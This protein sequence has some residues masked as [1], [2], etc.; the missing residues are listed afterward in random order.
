MGPGPGPKSKQTSPKIWSQV[1]GDLF[2]DL[3]AGPG[4]FFRRFFGTFKTEFWSL[5]L[6]IWEPLWENRNLIDFGFLYFVIFI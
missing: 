5:Q 1:F 4:P 6:N 2:F 3:G